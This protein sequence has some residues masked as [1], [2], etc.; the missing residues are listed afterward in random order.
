[1]LQCTGLGRTVFGGRI[2]TGNDAAID[3]RLNDR[4]GG[5]PEG[6]A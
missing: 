1:M 3:G 2:S 5:T 6:G 4:S